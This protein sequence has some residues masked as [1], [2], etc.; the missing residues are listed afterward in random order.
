MESSKILEVGL[1]YQKTLESIVANYPSGTCYL[2]GY[3]LA[4]YFKTK[5]FESKSVTGSLA[6]I[7]KNGK[8][9]VYGNLNIPKSNKIGS[10]HT[11]CEIFINDEWYILDPSLKYNKV[12]LIKIYRFKLNSKIPD[13]LFTNDKNTYV[14]KYIPNENL[15][16]ESNN[17]LEKASI[18]IKN[19]VIQS[20]IK[21]SII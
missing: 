20:L 1:L 19:E 8:Y 11:W 16:K 10:Y 13:L 17:F 12:T 21:S 4:E 14:W 15:V 6:L 5:G 18:E 9:I 7:D 2:A 3:C